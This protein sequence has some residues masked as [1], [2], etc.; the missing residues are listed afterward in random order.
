MTAKVQS[1][2]DAANGLLSAISSYTDATSAAATLKG[3]TTLRRLADQVLS[4]VSGAIGGTSPRSP[5]WS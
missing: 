2:V 5:G 1:L 4:T 3:D